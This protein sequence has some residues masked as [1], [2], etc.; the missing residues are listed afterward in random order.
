MNDHFNLFNWLMD[1]LPLGD[2]ITY[3]LLRKE[4]I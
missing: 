1:I 2:D 4:I 3:E